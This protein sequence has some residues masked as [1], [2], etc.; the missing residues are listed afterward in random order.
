MTAF[1][2]ASICAIILIKSSN[3]IAMKYKVSKDLYM[4]NIVRIRKKI[5]FI[6]II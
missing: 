6:A 2:N 1:G 3:D 4:A 5:A